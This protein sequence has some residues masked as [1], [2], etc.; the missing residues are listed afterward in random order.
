[1]SWSLT[2]QFH[3]CCLM[4]KLCLSKFV[5]N[6]AEIIF[7]QLG[8]WL[9]FDGG[10]IWF[11][12]RDYCYY[13]CFSQIQGIYSRAVMWTVRPT[14]TSQHLIRTFQHRAMNQQPLVTF[15]E[16]Y[17]LEILSQSNGWW[18]FQKVWWSWKIHRGLWISRNSTYISLQFLLRRPRLTS[19]GNE[20]L[21]R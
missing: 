10:N 8:L 3:N 21:V 12:L 6:L 13:T 15:I 16:H 19:I 20:V 18:E 17:L 4:V 14:S 1:M 11:T 9:M 5:S 2:K 7:L